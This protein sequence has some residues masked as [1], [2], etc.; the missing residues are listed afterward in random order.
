MFIIEQD[1]KGKKYL[2]NDYIA[3]NNEDKKDLEKIC[4]DLNTSEYA[5]YSIIELKDKF[6]CECC[7]EILFNKNQNKNE[8]KCGALRCEFCEDLNICSCNVD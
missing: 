1:I 3:Y 5:D 4:N 6:V 7:N 2:I 8:C